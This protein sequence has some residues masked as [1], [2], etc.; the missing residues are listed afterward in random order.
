MLGS[1]D[2]DSIVAHVQCGE[3]LYEI[4]RMQKKEGKGKMKHTVLFSKAPAR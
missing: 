4:E 1:F 2:A 3:R